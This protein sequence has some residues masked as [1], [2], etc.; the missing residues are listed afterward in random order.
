MIKVL[1]VVS[2]LGT[3]GIDSLIK[4]WYK[5][6]NDIIYDFITF[7]I[8]DS[9]DYYTQRGSSIYLF[10]PMREIGIIKYIKQFNSFFKTHNYEIV[11]SHILLC[12]SIVLF[13]AMKYKIKNRFAHSH[14]IEHT[15]YNN[16]I[17]PKFI[18]LIIEYMM[19]KVTIYSATKLLACSK[20]SGVYAYGSNKFILI[21]NGINCEKFSYN[22]EIRVRVRNILKI[23]NKLVIGHVGRLV[24]E[25]NQLFL[26][27]LLKYMKN[28][29][30]GISVILII[31]GDGQNMELLKSETKKMD[32]ENDVLFLGN[33]SDV[34]E[35]M[36]AFDV[37]VLPSISEGFG[38]VAIE[39]QAAGLKCFVSNVVSKDVDLTN[40]IYRLDI[41]QPR[42]WA[43]KILKESNYERIDCSQIVFK[44][45]Y[46]EYQTALEINNLYINSYYENQ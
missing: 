30:L 25:K 5:Y 16:D 18:S 9:N 43:I 34:N 13:I 44:K 11:H 19:K 17:M 15:F 36:Q 29:S 7:K 45:G 37:F 28:L 27:K 42:Q 2:G 32:I 31:V 35:L 38:I 1:H 24:E 46:D 20:E 21:R 22:S 4:S 26:L 41:N 6:S 3:G 40:L 12:S 39:A 33:R 10:K 23:N 8:G 14:G